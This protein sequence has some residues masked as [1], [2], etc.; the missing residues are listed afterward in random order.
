MQFHAGTEMMRSLDITI[1]E[2]SLLICVVMW[3]TYLYMLKLVEVSL[4][5]TITH[6]Q[7]MHLLVD[8]IRLSRLLVMSRLPLLLP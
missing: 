2:T 5:L 3:L 8:E 6:G 1:C 7:L 4:V